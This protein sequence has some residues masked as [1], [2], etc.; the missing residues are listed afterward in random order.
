MTFSKLPYEEQAGRVINGLKVDELG[1]DTVETPTVGALENRSGQTDTLNDADV[2]ES[3]I[4][5]SNDSQADKEEQNASVT[6]DPH[7]TPQDM[8]RARRIRVRLKCEM[9]CNAFNIVVLINVRTYVYVS[10]FP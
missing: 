6:T 10:V 2:L 1:Q 7:L 8:R 3:Q 5:A 9:K 4:S